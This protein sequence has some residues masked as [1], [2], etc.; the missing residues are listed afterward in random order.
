MAPSLMADNVPMLEQLL[1]GVPGVTPGRRK[2]AEPDWFIVCCP[3]ARAQAC[4][5][6]GVASAPV[7][8]PKWLKDSGK[9]PPRLSLRQGRR[10]GVSEDNTF[11]GL[12]ERLQQ[13][14]CGHDAAL[15]QH[16]DL[17]S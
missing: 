13:S 4:D 5:L 7:L 2:V 12:A 8:A 11:L 3:R 14:R 17:Q 6:A 10:K 9:G 15:R 16:R 1:R